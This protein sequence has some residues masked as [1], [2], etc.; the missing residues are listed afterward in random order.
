M[1]RSAW[2]RRFLSFRSARHSQRPLAGKPAPRFRPQLEQLEDRLVLSGDAVLHWNEVANQAAVLDHAIGGPGYQ[3]GPTRTSRAF[4]IVHAAIFDAVNSIDQSYT[5]YL[6]G[7]P[8]AP[9]NASIDAAAAQAGHDTLTALYPGFKPMFDAAL[10]ADLAGIPTTPA[11]LGEQVWQYVASQILAL[12]A[13]DGSQMDAPGQPV[14]YVYGQDPGQWRPDPL[15]PTAKPLTPDWGGV[16][17]FVVQS[18][19]QFGA[20]PPP[21]ITSKEYAD[22]YEQV[23]SLG[24]S[25]VGTPT[26]RTDEETTIGLFWGYDA[27]PGLCA[28][29]RF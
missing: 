23:K 6:V 24:G 14:T 4:A 17:P 8:N 22:A 2:N 13:N 7:Y 9:A 3:F 25:G 29:V 18:A 10:A 12:R 19:T 20:P 26:T 1:M 28:P 5:P 21:D 11:L 15:H 27:Q 16:A